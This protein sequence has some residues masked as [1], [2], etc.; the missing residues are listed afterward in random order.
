MRAARRAGPDAAL[1]RRGSSVSMSS[2]L[3]SLLGTCVLLGAAA[4][5]LAGL[6]GVGGGQVIVPGLLYL[7]AEQRVPEELRM[8]LALGT[9]LATIFLT[10]CASVHAHARLGA[11]HWQVVRR[12]GPGIIAGSLLGSRVAGALR[13]EVLAVVFGG[14][15]LALA[16]QMALELRPAAS[17]RLPGRVGLVGVG[18]AVGVVSALVGVGGGSMV[19]PLLTWCNVPMRNAVATAAACGLPLAASGALG[20]ALSGLGRAGLP[21]GSTGYVYWP[22]CLVLALASLGTAG[23]GA[24]L[25]HRLPTATLRRVFAAFLA[26]AGV[27]ILLR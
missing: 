8:H 1:R 2:T 10:S 24:R 5:L 20:F 13:G 16:L 6:L 4:G 19:V 21:P 22:A 9:S 11:V 12:L 14:F 23:F 3:L 18:G 26:I 25:A 27:R 7:F 15:L 17:R